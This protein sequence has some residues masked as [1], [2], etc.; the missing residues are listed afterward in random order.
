MMLANRSLCIIGVGLIGG[1]VAKA[2]RAR[3]MCGHVVGAGRVREH[4]ERALELGV[5]DAF[6][7]D[8]ARAV[9]NADIVILAVP[10]GAM[11][12]VME[13]IRESLPEDAVITDVGS[14]KGTVVED[15]RRCLGGHVGNF[16]PGHPI[17]GTEKSG[18]EA[19]FAGLFE[20][21]RVILT[22][23]EDDARELAELFRTHEPAAMVDLHDNPNDIEIA[24]GGAE[25]HHSVVA[26]W[27]A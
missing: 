11:A 18:V 6:E 4:L 1:S 21:R 17:A 22:P 13:T 3:D 10:L 8:L 14:A 16:V 20:G 5:I 25:P 15:A 7:T 19:A 26:V 24:L 12:D 2:L 9:A 27:W 23:T